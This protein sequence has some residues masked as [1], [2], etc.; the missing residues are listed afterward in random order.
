MNCLCACRGVKNPANNCI[1][2][3]L[4]VGTIF[5]FTTSNCGCKFNAP[6]CPKCYSIYNCKSNKKNFMILM[7]IILYPQCNW[8]I[9]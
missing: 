1:K 3:Y 7:W 2:D 6:V 4:N 9:R 5:L 8:T